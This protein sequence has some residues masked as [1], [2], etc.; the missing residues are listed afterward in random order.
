MVCEK[1]KKERRDDRCRHA[2][3]TLQQGRREAYA[4]LLSGL[5]FADAGLEALGTTMTAAVKFLG[6]FDLLVGH[7]IAP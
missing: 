4:K 3:N 1:R 2:G 7:D 6:A 5:G